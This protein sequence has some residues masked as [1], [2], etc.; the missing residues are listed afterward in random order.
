[1]RIRF[2]L[3]ALDD[4]V[5]IREYLVER[6]GETQAARIGARI[7]ASIDLLLQFPYAGHGGEVPGTRV[8]KVTGQPYIVIYRVTEETVEVVH[9][10]HERQDRPCPISA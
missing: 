7:R 8:R 3:A 1:V 6:H 5:R 10:Y 2:A 9:V 4:L